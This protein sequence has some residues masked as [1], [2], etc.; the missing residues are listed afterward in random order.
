[1]TT[2]RAKIISDGTPVGTKVFVNDQDIS[3][4]VVGIVWRLGMYGE[5]IAEI[6]I[7]AEID[8]EVDLYPEET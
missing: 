2:P 7:R 4:Q 1:M 3:E 6:K 5:A 8:A